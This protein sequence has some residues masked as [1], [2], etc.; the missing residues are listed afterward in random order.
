MCAEIKDIIVYH[1]TVR[2]ELARIKA[3]VDDLHLIH[4]RPLTGVL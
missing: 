3:L 1:R 2:I 4:D